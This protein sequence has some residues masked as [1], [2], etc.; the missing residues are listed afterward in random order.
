[1]MVLA[2]LHSEWCVNRLYLL[3]TTFFFFMYMF[4]MK[5]LKYVY[6]YVDMH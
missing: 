2:P 6:M 5:L 3:N 1:M 4:I